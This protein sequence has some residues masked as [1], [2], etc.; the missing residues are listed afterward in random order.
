M[1]EF[2]YVGKETKFIT[3][4]FKNTNVKVAFTTDNRVERLLSTQHKQIQIKYDKCRNYQLTCPTCK[5][6]YTGQTDRPFR[7]RFQEHF[8]DFKYGTNKSQFTQ[9]LLGNRHFI[10]LMENVTETIQITNNDRMMDTLE[11]F[12]TCKKQNLIIRSMTD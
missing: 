5:M 11:R 8:Q 4:L 3:Q 12:Y 10:G 9:H 1:A 2:T 7:V 6:K